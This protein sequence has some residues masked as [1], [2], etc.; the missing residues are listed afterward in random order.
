MARSISSSIPN[1]ASYP[2]DQP[3]P[4]ARPIV[5][6]LIISDDESN[7]SLLQAEAGRDG[8]D[9]RLAPDTTRAL[10]SHRTDWVPDAIVLDQLMPRAEL[11]AV[12]R[13]VRSAFAVPVFVVSDVTESSTYPLH[14]G[15]L[16]LSR[17]AVVHEI[18]HLIALAARNGGRIAAGNLL[19]DTRTSRAIFHGRVI[20]LTWDETAILAALMLNHGEAVSCR[21]LIASIGGVQRDL[22]P[23][24]IDVHIARLMM[25]FGL[26][27]EVRIEQTPDREGYLLR[28]IA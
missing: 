25:R 22:D 2:A 7:R 3:M 4:V 26:T 23:L 27:T 17:N 19:L 1:V 24:V 15:V 14:Q 20:D 5:R 13:E 21:T 28:S 8:L 16:F 9:A 12:V 6:I 11:Y 18:R 10:E